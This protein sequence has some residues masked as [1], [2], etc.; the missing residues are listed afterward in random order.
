MQMTLQV[1]E[2]RDWDSWLGNHQGQLWGKKKSPSGTPQEACINSYP[3][4]LVPWPWL[5]APVM[6]Q[7]PFLQLPSPPPAVV[8]SHSLCSHPR[9]RRTSFHWEN[10]WCFLEAGDDSFLFP[11]I[12]SMARALFSISFPPFRKEQKA[13]V[14]LWAGV[15]VRPLHPTCVLSWGFLL[16]LRFHKAFWDKL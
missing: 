6:L 5:Q 1:V 4:W 12:F 2:T 3:F 11:W 14:G 8:S 7:S 16:P 13:M 15:Y 9:Y 10:S